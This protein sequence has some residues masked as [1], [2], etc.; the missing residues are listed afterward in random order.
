MLKIGPGVGFY[1]PAEYELKG[2][3]TVRVVAECSL[4]TALVYESE[5]QTD[6]NDGK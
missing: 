4:N 6:V 3:C 5:L 2:W 1:I